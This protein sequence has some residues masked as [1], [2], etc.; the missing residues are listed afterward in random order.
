MGVRNQK[1]TV[2]LLRIVTGTF[3]YKKTNTLPYR[4]VNCVKWLEL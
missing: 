3:N 1:K 2:L 4:L